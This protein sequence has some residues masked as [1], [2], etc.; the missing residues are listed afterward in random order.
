MPPLTDLLRWSRRYVYGLAAAVLLL[1]VT[2]VMAGYYIHYAHAIDAQIMGGPFRDSINIY[3]AASV[4]S[5]GDTV[6]RQELDSELRM[7]GHAPRVQVVFGAKNRIEKIES[8][9][10]E[11]KTVSLGYPLLENL[12]AGREKRRMVTFQELPPILVNAIV[13]AEDKHFFHHTGLDLPRVAKAAYVDIREHRKEQGASTLTMQL[14]RGLWLEPKK[15]WNRKIVEA[16]MTVHLEHK[17]SKQE[18][19][20]AYA[21]LVF[22]GK[23]AAYNI[24]GFAEASQLFFDKDIHDLNLPEAALLAGM[25]Q[26]PSYFNP[27][28]NPE[29]AKA[30]RDL[31]LSLM[32]E[33]KYITAGEYQRAVATPLMVVKP[34][35]TTTPLA[36][37]I[38]WIWLATSCSPSI[39]RK[40]A[41][42]IS[43]RPSI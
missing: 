5:V 9:G 17:W 36:L 10:H 31:V 28:R 22:L 13:S 6:T 38:F 21:N 39:N 35:I 7:A 42:R 34:A 23:Q 33:N 4:L 1:A 2:A 24:H 18:I 16:M 26:R 14:V 15:S 20:G 29:H 3:G 40:T 27:Y 19:L 8:D 32:L 12:S 43:I 37:P 11:V 41:Q 30:R 25:V